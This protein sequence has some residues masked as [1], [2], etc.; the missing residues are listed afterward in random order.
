MLFQEDFYLIHQ[1][2]RTRKTRTTHSHP[3]QQSTFER[4]SPRTNR[5]PNQT[6]VILPSEDS[7]LSNGESTPQ[8]SDSSSTYHSIEENPIVENNRD[9]VEVCIRCNQ[10]GHRRSTCDT[11]IRSFTHCDICAW[12]GQHTCDHYDVSPAWIQRQRQNIA[13]RTMN[14]REICD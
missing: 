1:Y 2:Y 6:E 5:S 12:T 4:P 9:D 13:N 7:A 11:P 14:N 8:P 10:V 3:H